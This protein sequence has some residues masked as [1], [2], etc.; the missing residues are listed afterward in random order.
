MLKVEEN[1]SA[2][3]DLVQH[4][5]NFFFHE[6]ETD[7]RA[8]ATHLSQR[9]RIPEEEF[10]HFVGLSEEEFADHLFSRR[11]RWEAKVRQNGLIDDL[12]GW[13]FYENNNEIKIL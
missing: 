6:P 10:R 12:N 2:V 11:K 13:N 7:K 9:S 1:R 3:P 8:N 5:R 4:A